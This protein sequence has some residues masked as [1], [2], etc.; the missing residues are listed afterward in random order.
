MTDERSTPDEA[1]LTPAQREQL[2]HLCDEFESHW[3]QQVW[4]SIGD[5]LQG[6]D[7][8][9]RSVL[10]RELLGIETH[11]RER[12][13]NTE[14]LRNELL[15]RFP[16][17]AAIVESVLG[18]GEAGNHSLTLS[19]SALGH[20]NQLEKI[21]DGGFGLVFRAWDTRHR[22]QVALKVPRFAHQLVGR[23]LEEFF[24]EAKAAGSLDHPNIARVWD[25]GTTAGVTYIAYQLVDGENL[26]LRLEE[27]TQQAPLEIVAFVRQLA[28]AVHYAHQQGIIHRD[29]KPSNILITKENQP[30]LT[31]FGLAL[32]VGADATRSLAARIGTLDYMSPEQAIGAQELIGER[33]D[34]WS[35]GVVLYELLTGELPFQGATDLQLCSNICDAPYKRPGLLRRGVPKDLEIVIDRCLQKSPSDRLTSCGELAEE[36][37]RIESGHPIRSR[38]VSFVERALRW[39]RRNPRPMI[40]FAAILSATV[41]GA[42]SWG[43][44]LAESQQNENVVQ[45]LQ[46]ELEIK[47]AE[48]RELLSELITSDPTEMT[49][50]QQDLA[51]LETQLLAS[52]DLQEQRFCAETLIR[53]DWINTER[54]PEKSAKREKVIGILRALLDD[55]KDSSFRAA[56]GAALRQ[57]GDTH[58]SN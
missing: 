11:W 21:G 9:L 7:D 16:K 8:P 33:T 22:R 26:K 17:N 47:N 4:P 54:Y 10:L 48:R 50:L 13:S 24:R 14:L 12:A 3:Q 45:Q 38:R 5:Y 55:A 23:E 31:D 41:F 51:F 34:L 36:L 39:I 58:D 52:T 35:L 15:D 49:Y 2:D 42:W 46:L 40:A 53:N 20:F 28:M 32:A 56:L 44:R 25:S 57:V 27:F 18:I 43:L 19:A 37:A 1:N 30:V 6:V 29:I